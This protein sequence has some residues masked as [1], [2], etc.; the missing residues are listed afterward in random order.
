[1][2]FFRRKIF[3]L[4]LLRDDRTCH[5]ACPNG[6]PGDVRRKRTNRDRLSIVLRVHPRRM[7]YSKEVVR[8]TAIIAL[9]S[10]RNVIIMS[11]AHVR[12]LTHARTHVRRT[13]A[14]MH[15]RRTYAR[16]RVRTHV[17]T[18]VHTHVRTFA[19][20]HAT[21]HVRTNARSH[22]R[23]HTRTHT[24]THARNYTR[25]HVRKRFLGARWSTHAQ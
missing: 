10:Q 12:V 11:I 1:M 6:S 14:H 8:H 9:W 19:R 17:H 5:T 23:P 22:I 21:T 20:T 18:H 16:T 2:C 7:R 4:L 25:S 15:M 24:R 3:A 13:H